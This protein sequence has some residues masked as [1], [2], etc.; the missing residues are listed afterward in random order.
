MLASVF[1]WAQQKLPLQSMG[2]VSLGLTLLSVDY[3]TPIQGSWI[4]DSKFGT[5]PSATIENGKYLPAYL[6]QSLFLSSEARYLYSFTKRQELGRD[7]ALNSASY[8]GIKARYNFKPYPGAGRDLDSFFSRRDDRK[9]SNTLSLAG[10]WGLQRNLDSNFL[11]NIYIGPGYM[12]D[13]NNKSS[14]FYPDLG[15]VFSYVFIKSKK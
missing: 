4:L 3:Q 6:A 14:S 11:F 12:I 1:G 10:V 9:Y 15:L 7:I 2:K 8:F 5:G 13:F